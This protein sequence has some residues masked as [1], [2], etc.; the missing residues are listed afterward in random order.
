[1]R[2]RTLAALALAPFAPRPALA[3][4][5]PTRPVQIVVPFPPGGGTDVLLR[6]LTPRLE[7]AL[8][9]PFI[10]D[11][12][13]GASG[14]IGTDRVA[15]APPDGYT[16]L[17]QATII[18]VYPRTI[19]DVRY[20]PLKDLAPI[21][22]MAETPNVFVVSPSFAVTTLPELM[23]ASKRRPLTF[24]TAGV[25]TPQ[26]LGTMAIAKSLGAQV[27]HIPYRGTAP[28][29]TDLIGRQVDFAVFSLSSVLPLIRE[30]RLK[31][32]AVH[33]RKRDELA[34]EIP[35]SLEQGVDDAG[36]GLRFLLFAPAA[37]PA[38]IVTTL[39]TALNTILRDP[40]I[41]RGF[42]ERG[43]TV[44]TSTPAE[45][46]REMERELRLWTPVLDELDLAPAQ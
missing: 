3:Q 25:G 18:S 38:P 1:M 9:Q 27:E 16:L 21:G 39:N 30:G 14:S 2:R 8:G 20:D 37:T 32:L 13:A 5:Y 33:A 23:A 35:S 10:I 15:K 11:N 17:A 45:A 34:P 44:L 43:Y 28:A 36:S 6:L 24:A 42:R 12:R 41:V 31:A 40:E 19:S 26:H 29:V 22:M 46:Q 7:R 4:A